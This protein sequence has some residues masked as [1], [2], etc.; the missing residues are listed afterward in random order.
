MINNLQISA[1]HSQLT[2]ELRT[3]VRK[4]IGKLDRYIPK[5]ARA[6]TFVEVKIKE[7]KS[8]NKQDFECEVIMK[9]PKG[10]IT[11]HENSMSALAAVDEVENNLKNQL[12]KY[13]DLHTLSR[14]RRQV[15]AKFK[16]D[17]PANN[18]Y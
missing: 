8:R 16:G 3:Y 13:K 11:A 9:L 2:D 17:I 14:V 7:K 10:K 12:K 15:I 6:S 4:K 1:L 5:N 18:P